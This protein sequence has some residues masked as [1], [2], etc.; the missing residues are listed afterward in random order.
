MH[1]RAGVECRGDRVR[2]DEIIQQMSLADKLT[3][4]FTASLFF[5]FVPNSCDKH[6]NFNMLETDL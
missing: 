6:F 5:L 2:C 3:G 1:F 4:N